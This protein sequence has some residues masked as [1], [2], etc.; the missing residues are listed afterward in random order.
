[1]AGEELRWRCACERR[2]CPEESL[3]RG[4]SKRIMQPQNQEKKNEL[5]GKAQETAAGARERAEQ[6]AQAAKDKSIDT[7][8]A[9]KDKASELTQAAKDRASEYAQEAKEKTSNTSQATKDKAS[10]LTQ[11]AKDKASDTSPTSNNKM[12]DTTQAAKKLSAVEGKENTGGGFLQQIE[13]HKTPMASKDQEQ[14]QEEKNEMMGKLHQMAVK[15]KERAKH[16][17]QLIKNS[18]PEATR[19]GK[20]TISETTHAATDN[21][22]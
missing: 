9:A 5:T 1:M 16:A 6:A 10:G 2:P 7:T 14:T 4:V 8:Q 20:N 15:S 21:D 13:E 3:G 18:S 19:A 12:S 11:A 17:A 22:I